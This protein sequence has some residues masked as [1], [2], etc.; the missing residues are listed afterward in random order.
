[1][2]RYKVIVM[3][4]AEEDIHELAWIIHHR[5]HQPD[6]AAKMQER[7]YREIFSLEKM[8][9]RYAL[10]QDY[11]LAKQG[12]RVASVANYLIF[13]VVNKKEKTVNIIRVLH[14]SLDLDLRKWL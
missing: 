5:L 9:E 13:Y 10:S 4:E 12:Y 6:T 1:M 7:I 14:G 8:P 3:P 11:D 2:D